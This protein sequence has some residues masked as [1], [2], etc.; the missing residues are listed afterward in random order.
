M[1]CYEQKSR[2]NRQKIDQ[3]LFLKIHFCVYTIQLDKTSSSNILSYCK[4]MKG[5][6]L[7]PNFEFTFVPSLLSCN[8]R[9]FFLKTSIERVVLRP[10]FRCSSVLI[11]QLLL[12]LQGPC[13]LRG[14]VKERVLLNPRNII[15]S[16]SILP[17][18]NRFRVTVESEHYSILLLKTIAA[19]KHQLIEKFYFL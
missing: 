7:L 17:E 15:I 14:D 13:R 16:K 6:Q 19:K 4:V 2:L 8:L 9:L 18:E 1:I 5:F 11:N 3:K 12:Y 10:L